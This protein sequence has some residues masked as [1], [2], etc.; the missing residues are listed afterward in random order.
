MSI[1]FYQGQTDLLKNVKPSSSET[2]ED[3]NKKEQEARNLDDSKIEEIKKRI[4]EFFNIKNIHFLLGSGTSC[5]A[6]PNMKG[7]YK[8]VVSYLN[9]KRKGVS[10]EKKELYQSVSDEFCSIHKRVKKKGG[11]NLEEVLG[12][13]YSNRTYL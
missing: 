5:N 3:E 9:K 4:A 11:Y 7:L 12:I 10:E 13:L 6:I 8:E 2:P 1:N